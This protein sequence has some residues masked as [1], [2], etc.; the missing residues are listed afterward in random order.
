[1]CTIPPPPAPPPPP[2]PL[3][4]SNRIQDSVTA[5]Q[6]T[7]TSKLI[8]LEPDLCSWTSS[9]PEL[10]RA[11]IFESVCTDK[12]PYRI[13]YT[14]FTPI[15]QVGPTCGLVALSMVINGKIAPD[16]ILDISKSEGYSSNG[17]MFSCKNMAKLAGKV[18]G[19]ASI[20]DINVRVNSRSL[21]SPETVE[22]LLEG[23]VL[24][25]PYDADVNHT[26]S[27]KNGHTAHWALIC[28]VILVKKPEAPYTAEKD[29]IYVLCR[30]GKSKYL[31]AWNLAKL[32]QSNNNLWEFSPKKHTDG[33][34]YVLPEGGIGG[35]NGLRGQ[36]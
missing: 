11:C 22:S 23:A 35:N 5:D 4:S 34:V 17:E 30:H 32:A 8:E 21:F 13:K 7:V 29:N 19:S 36:L 3:P 6:F 15:T 9:D 24:L 27:L 2:P 16:K 12:P 31:C 33:L 20:E 14:K 1:M 10:R 26:P 28:G 18:F 25:V